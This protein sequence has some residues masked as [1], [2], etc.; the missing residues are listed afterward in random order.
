MTDKSS[1]PLHARYAAAVKEFRIAYSLLA[2]SD[3]R[4]G[5]TGFG[6]PPD[7]ILFRHALANPNE[8]GSLHED[9]AAAR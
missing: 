4:N 5:R 9:I 2:A 1:M 8:G 7:I 3:Q 6:P